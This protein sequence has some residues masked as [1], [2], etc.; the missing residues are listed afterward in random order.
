MVRRESIPTLVD[1]RGTRHQLILNHVSSTML[2]F[3]LAE[4]A[5]DLRRQL[6][7]LPHGRL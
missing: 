7:V 5:A 3:A 2:K 1:F 4:R 6:R